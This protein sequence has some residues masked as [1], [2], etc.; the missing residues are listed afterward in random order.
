MFTVPLFKI[1]VAL[2]A[3]WKTSKK[4]KNSPLPPPRPWILKFYNTIK[5]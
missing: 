5:L 3:I 2:V 4:F 1:I